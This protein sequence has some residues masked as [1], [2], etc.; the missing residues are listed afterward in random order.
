MTDPNPSSSRTNKRKFRFGS[1]SATLDSAE[2]R[3]LPIFFAAL[4]ISPSVLFMHCA[5]LSCDPSRVAFAKVAEA[6]GELS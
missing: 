2:A 4:V 6:A 1:R 3:S 5:Y